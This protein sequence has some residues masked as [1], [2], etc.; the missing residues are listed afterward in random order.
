MFQTGT[1]TELQ[2]TDDAACLDGR[3]GF[4]IAAGEREKVGG[5]N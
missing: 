3:W 2:W 5:G 4:C 1:G